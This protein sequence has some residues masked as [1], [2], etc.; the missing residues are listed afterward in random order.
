MD[1][2]RQSNIEL[3][4][5]YRDKLDELKILLGQ[6]YTQLELDT[7]LENAIAYSRIDTADYLLTLGA[8]FENYN[9]QGVY[10]AVHNNKLEG[11]K[12]AISKGVDINVNEGQLLRTSIIT[13]I[14]SKDLTLIKWLL[15]NGASVKYL[16]QEHFDLVDRYGTKEFK[17]LIKTIRHAGT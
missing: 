5:G 14:N 11:L 16:N 1:L 17:E 4:A 8:R 13:T 2:D 3:L 6:S 7:A 9:Y 12:Y 10:Y 15:D